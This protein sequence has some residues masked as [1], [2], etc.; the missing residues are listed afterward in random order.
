M[1]Y[2]GWYFDEEKGRLMDP[3]K[4]KSWQAM[5]NTT[6]RGIK[7]NYSHFCIFVLLSHV[8]TQGVAE[9]LAAKE[10]FTVSWNSKN[11]IQLT[12][13]AVCIREHQH[14]QEEVNAYTTH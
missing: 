12:H 2:E 6:D 3:L 14:T 11:E 7:S 4:T 5:F 13:D 8:N 10:N 9:A 1:S